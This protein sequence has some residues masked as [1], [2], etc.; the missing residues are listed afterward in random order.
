MPSSARKELDKNL[1]EINTLSEIHAAL[2]GP[3]PG[4]KFDLEI[5]NKGSIVMICGAWEAY[6]EDIIHEAISI[7]EQDCPS[8]DKLPKL[9]KKSAQSNVRKDTDEGAPWKLA[10]S[11]WRNFIRQLSEIALKQ[12]TGYFN[13]PKS[14]KL[15]DFFET[16]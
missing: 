11:G 16:V 6:C 15:I 4:R 1:Q 14:T 3:K 5:L 8:P 12:H 10:E 7:I 13:T 9:L 2:A